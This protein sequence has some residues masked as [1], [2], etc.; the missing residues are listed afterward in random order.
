M[1]NVKILE[2]ISKEEN[3]SSS[4]IDDKISL[5]IDHFLVFRDT[6]ASYL[7]NTEGEYILY[8]TPQELHKAIK[9][10]VDVT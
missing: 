2:D 8:G 1:K 5:I 10:V 3:T 7:Y 6:S 9:E 4:S